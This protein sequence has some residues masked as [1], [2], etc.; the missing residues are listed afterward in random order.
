MPHL[1][2]LILTMLSLSACTV[3]TPPEPTSTPPPVSTQKAIETASGFCGIGHVVTLET[4][5]NPHARLVTLQRA[6][7]LLG[8]DFTS[9]RSGDQLVWLVT[10]EGTWEVAFNP[11]PTSTPVGQISPTK[12]PTLL[13]ACSAIIDA[14]TGQGIGILNGRPKE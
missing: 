3:F 14:T 5:Y 7:E 13:H 8:V 11:R 10:V 1:F 12:T 9:G 2:T 4:P 6:S